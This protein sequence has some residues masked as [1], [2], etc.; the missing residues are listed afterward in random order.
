MSLAMTR[1]EREAFLADVHVGVINIPEPGRGGLTVPIWYDYAPGGPLWFVTD[2]ESRKARLLEAAGCLSLCVQSEEAP[3]RYVSVEGTVRS[4]EP[5]DVERD[6]RPLA[7]RYLGREAGD[8]YIAA[9]HG[10]GGSNSSIVVRVDL[11]RW[12]SVDYRKQFATL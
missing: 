4:I 8:R 10:E 6:T 9:T 5:A 12:L 3:Y 2:A 1:A 7:H 11:R